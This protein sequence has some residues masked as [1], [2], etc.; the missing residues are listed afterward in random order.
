MKLTI[1][2]LLIIELYQENVNE[3]HLEAPAR[4]YTLVEV[5]L[6]QLW[7]FEKFSQNYS[8]YCQIKTWIT[9]FDKFWDEYSS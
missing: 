6:Y 9:R 3:V 5:L 8:R 4:G 2:Y 7:A 1:K